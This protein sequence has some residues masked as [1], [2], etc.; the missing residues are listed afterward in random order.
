MPTP[1]L[2][3]DEGRQHPDIPRRESDLDRAMAIARRRLLE[4]GIELAGSESSP[5]VVRLLTAGEDFERAVERRGGDTFI[6]TRRSSQPE[7][8]EW[9]VPA[10]AA[11]ESLDAYIRRIEDVTERIAGDVT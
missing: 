11:D 4:R 7:N 3:S 8:P 5:L 1:L 2:P 10:R 9:V 6:N